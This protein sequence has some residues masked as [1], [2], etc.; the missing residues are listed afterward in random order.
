MGGF[1][2]P[3]PED[4]VCPN[5]GVIVAAGEQHEC[6]EFNPLLTLHGSWNFL[7]P[8]PR[9]MYVEQ[10]AR[11]AYHAVKSLPE[12]EWFKIQR[13]AD[14]SRIGLFS[15]TVPKRPSGKS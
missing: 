14:D 12:G 4:I 3:G 11:A 8:L 6:E 9:D 15:I 2:Q 1:L 10:V 5:C 13:N 7:E